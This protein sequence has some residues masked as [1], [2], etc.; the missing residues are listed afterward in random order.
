MNIAQNWPQSAI[1][2]DKK[3]MKAGRHLIKLSAKLTD[4][5]LVIKVDNMDKIKT[6]FC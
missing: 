5:L 4:M 2:I 1:E 3:A 6:N